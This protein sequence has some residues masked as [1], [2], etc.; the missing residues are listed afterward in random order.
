[1]DKVVRVS[2]RVSDC[3]GEFGERGGDSKLTRGF[4][5]D[6]VAA[7]QRFCINARPAVM[8]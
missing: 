7:R 3:L 1:M 6:F 8:I 2:T 4:G 5:G